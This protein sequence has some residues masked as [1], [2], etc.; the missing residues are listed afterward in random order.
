MFKTL[1]SELPLMKTSP[2]S[3]KRYFTIILMAGLMSVPHAGSAIQG[4]AS[5]LPSQ[6]T[7]HKRAER[8]D[9]FSQYQQMAQ[10]LKQARAGDRKAGKKA[11]Q[12]LRRLAQSAEA[13]SPEAQL[14]IGHVY[15]RGTMVKTNLKK[16]LS[17]YRK[18]AEQGLAGAQYYVGAFYEEGI[19]VRPDAKEAARWYYKAAKGRD[20]RAQEK[21]AYLFAT[22]KNGV[23]KDPKEAVKWIRASRKQIGEAMSGREAAYYLSSKIMENA[24]PGKDWDEVTWWLEQAA[25]HGSAPAQNRLG[26]FYSGGIGVAK[27]KKEAVRWFYKAAQQGNADAQYSLGQSYDQGIG[28]PQSYVKAAQWYGQAAQQGNMKAAQQLKSMQRFLKTRAMYR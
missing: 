10:A 15:A 26:D 3:S 27:D 12:W 21:L 28:V 20:L 24:R 1:S 8:G 17:W 4:L 2:L 23:R 25:S 5:L 11:E 13:G 18:A 9:A 22:G 14:F 7:M 16:A 19:G 6:A